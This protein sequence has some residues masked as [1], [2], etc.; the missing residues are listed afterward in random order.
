MQPSGRSIDDFLSSDNARDATVF[1]LGVVG[2]NRIESELMP[3]AMRTAYERLQAAIK[4]G[5]GRAASIH[6]K[7]F[8]RELR[9]YIDQ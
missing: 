8:D 4:R 5:D 3:M 7:E 6:R 1:G 9:S 2:G